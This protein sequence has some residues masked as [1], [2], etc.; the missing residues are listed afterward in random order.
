[1]HPFG[2]KPRLLI[3]GLLVA[4]LLNPAL[5]A[6]AQGSAAPAITAPADGDVVQG[7]VA[8]RGTTDVPN[9]ASSELAFGYAGDSTD[10]WFQIHSSSLPVS[11]DVIAVWDTTSITDGAYVL[12]LRV[13]LLD[14][15]TQDARISL[16]V[17]NY[18]QPPTPTPTAAPA[19]TATAQPAIQ[20]PTAVI[21]SA[22]ETPTTAPV[23]LATPSALPPNPAG[24]T[25]GEVFSG[26][27]KGALLV[28]ALVLVFSAV[29]R[30][31][32]N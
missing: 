6:A 31:R 30:L 19:V 13:N 10:T 25:P 21:I 24:I 23:L 22:S 5:P 27:W 2:Q 18:T 12:R 17:R 28:G 1:V 8:I 7:P 3:A 9:F 11:N 4:L 16:Q 14:G 15:T 29:A 26:F 32:R 20:I